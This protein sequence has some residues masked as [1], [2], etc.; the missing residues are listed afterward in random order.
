MSVKGPIILV[1]DDREDREIT[2]EAIKKLDLPNKVICFP[3]GKEALDYLKTTT[4]NPFIIFSDIDMPVLNGLQFRNEIN[5]NERL[6]KKSIP[7]VFLTS[8]VTKSTVDLA[9]ELTVQGFFTK[10][11]SFEELQAQLSLVLEYWKT[12]RHPNSI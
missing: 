12:A 11:H 4:D 7:F 6:R 5:K 3:N 1:D 10:L 8:T 2:H 9:Y